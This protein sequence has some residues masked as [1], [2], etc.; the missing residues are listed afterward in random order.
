MPARPAI[1][2]RACMMYLMVESRYPCLRIQ[3]PKDRISPKAEGDSDGF[4]VWR[5]QWD[6]YYR[7]DLPKRRKLAQILRNSDLLADAIFW[8]CSTNK[9][10]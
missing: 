9:K 2:L 8:F 7:L 1:D 4:V 10:Q 6:S 3:N 5:S